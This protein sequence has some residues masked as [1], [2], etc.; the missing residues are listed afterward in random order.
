MRREAERNAGHELHQVG[1][2]CRV[3][4]EVSMQMID[5]FSAVPFLWDQQVNQMHSLKKTFP[6]AAGGIAIIDASIRYDIQQRTE[7]SSE[8]PPSYLEVFVE[9]IPPGLHLVFIQI[10]NRCLNLIY[11]HLNNLLTRIGQGKDLDRYTDLFQRQDLV[12]DKG[13]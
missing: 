10:M 11:L 1:N 8:M 5:H 4:R 9:P 13:L 7:I 12:Q 2:Q 3:M 6:A